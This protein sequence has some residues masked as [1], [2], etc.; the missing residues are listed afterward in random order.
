M[1]TFTEF[2]SKVKT[3][4]KTGF[5]KVSVE[6]EKA[7]D[8]ATLLVKQ[9]AIK[10]K[11]SDYYEELGKLTYAQVSGEG[12]EA[13]EARVAELMSLIAAKLEEQTAIREELDRRKAEKE[14][15]RGAEKTEHEATAEAPVG[16]ADDTTVE[17]PSDTE[18]TA[19]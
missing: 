12:S 15:K 5:K 16:T 4:L 2:C 14:A 8:T 6:V 13:T 10:M 9:G 1:A 7:A 17:L 18:G 3:R 19:E 11:L